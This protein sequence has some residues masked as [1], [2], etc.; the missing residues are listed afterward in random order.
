MEDVKHFNIEKGI[1]QVDVSEREGRK[2][3][4]EIFF[5][6]HSITHTR[7]HDTHTLTFTHVCI[8][9]QAHIYTLTYIRTHTHSL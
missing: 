6:P 4:G 3:S 5:L 2:M 7:T 8:N 9:T 1:F